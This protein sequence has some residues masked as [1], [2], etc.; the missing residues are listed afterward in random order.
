MNARMIAWVTGLTA[1]AAGSGL[2]LVAVNLATFAQREIP[3]VL[4]E[5][6]PRPT[7]A[8][9]DRR[10]GDMAWVPHT[11]A[12]R[13]TDAEA[14]FMSALTE[15]AAAVFDVP[16]DVL[17]REVARAT[18][19]YHDGTGLR[20]A[21][22]R[23]EIIMDLNVPPDLATTRTARAFVD[24]LGRDPRPFDSYLSRS[25]ELGVAA[26]AAYLAAQKAAFAEHL[27]NLGVTP[28]DETLWFLAIVVTR[29]RSN[30]LS[31]CVEEA[32]GMGPVRLGRAFADLVPTVRLLADRSFVLRAFLREWQETDARKMSVAFVAEVAALAQELG[33]SGASNAAPETVAERTRT[34]TGH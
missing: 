23:P 26:R 10:N 19:P 29:G 33:P 12:D 21:P 32:F 1:A 14:R 30:E 18:L 13:L 7:F 5:S 17:S 27:E 8:L 24:F 11:A 20:L 16:L 6:M 25:A 22:L 4:P 2:V 31:A 28:S 9:D 3:T 34:A 15:R